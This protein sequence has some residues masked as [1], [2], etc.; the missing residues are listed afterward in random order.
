MLE[1]VIR[2][3]YSKASVTQAV[4]IPDVAAAV[5]QL[6]LTAHRETGQKISTGY[7]IVT[8]AVK[9]QLITPLN[10]DSCDK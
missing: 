1:I 2:L 9:Y 5:Q 7:D 10:I 6:V 8:R 3:I 4:L